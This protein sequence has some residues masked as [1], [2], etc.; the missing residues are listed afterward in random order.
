[1]RTIAVYIKLAGSK[2]AENYLKRFENALKAPTLTWKVGVTKPSH[3]RT[4]RLSHYN[5]E[6]TLHENQLDY[7]LEVAA[8]KLHELIHAT[9]MRWYKSPTTLSDIKNNFPG[10]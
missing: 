6:I 5:Y 9:L 7:P 3:G 2:L 10:I 4:R 1:M 8:T